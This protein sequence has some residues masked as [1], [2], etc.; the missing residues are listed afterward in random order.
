MKRA[1]KDIYRAINSNEK[2]IYSESMQ[3]RK[4]EIFESVSENEMH[5]MI[6]N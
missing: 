6:F 4:A 2:R 3:E 5:K 1:A